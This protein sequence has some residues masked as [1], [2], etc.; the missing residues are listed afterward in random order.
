MATIPSGEEE[1]SFSGGSEFD[2]NEG[3]RGA[4]KLGEGKLGEGKL[5][6]GSGGSSGS[7]SG[8]SS[9]VRRGSS[10]GIIMEAVVAFRTSTGRS[11]KYPAT[12]AV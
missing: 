12:T 9:G 1:L 5:G 4:D 8:L 10:L 7:S 11:P 2:R 3:T 6:E